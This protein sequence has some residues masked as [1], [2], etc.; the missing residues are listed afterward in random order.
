MIRR[1][2]SVVLVI[3]MAFGLSSIAT[4]AQSPLAPKDSQENKVPAVC[5]ESINSIQ[6]QKVEQEPTLVLVMP[7]FTSI[8]GTRLSECV[9]L[10]AEDFCECHCAHDPDP[11]CWVKNC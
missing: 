4:L 10:G 2:S 6:T 3:S 11:A 9:G 5:P 7:G 8:G 1:R